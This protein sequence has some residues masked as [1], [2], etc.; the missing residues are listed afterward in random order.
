MNYILITP[1]QNEEQNLLRLKDTIFRQTVIPIIW[2]IVDSNSTDRSYQVEIDL[3]EKYEW[4]H[5]IKQKRVFDQGYSHKNFAE[6]INEGYEYAKKMCTEQKL[7]YSFVGKTD[8]TPILANNYFEKLMEVMVNN[9][10]L[11]ITCGL[12]EL[13]LNESTKIKIKPLAGI[14]NT[15]FNDIR[16]YSKIFLDEVGFYPLT[17]SPD[18][19]LLIKA[20]DHGWESKI[21]D[22]TYFVKSRLGGSKIGIWNGYKLKGRGMYSLGYHPLLFLFNVVY[23]SLKFPPHYQGFPMLYEFLNCY[24]KK[25]KRV[26]D[27]EILEYF[28]KKRLKEIFFHLYPGLTDPTK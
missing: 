20:S 4:I 8:A 18:T 10:N 27:E 2:V 3:F 11:A 21:V 16:L 12:Q 1:I 22:E 6:A 5:I 28:G 7:E 19:I 24:V 17:Y 23:T 13:L 14:C 25:E 9:P 26:E 15:G